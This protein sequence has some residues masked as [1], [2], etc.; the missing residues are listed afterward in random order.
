MST[1][2]TGSLTKQLVTAIMD[3]ASINGGATVRELT[4]GRVYVMRPPDGVAFPFVVVRLQSFRTDP[5]YSQ[6]RA[7]GTLE[8]TVYA[9]PRSRAEEA[10]EIA[11][12]IVQC[13]LNYTSAV[14]GMT[15]GTGLSRQTLPMMSDPADAD[16]VAIR[17]AA[18]FAVWPLFL[19]G[20][21]PAA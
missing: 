20:G 13:L 1:E 4:T 12:R 14:Q 8:C 16:V 5:N 17:V 21:T 3:T 11:D 10:E 18:D 15:F 7:T 19:T 2:S 9:R 6:L